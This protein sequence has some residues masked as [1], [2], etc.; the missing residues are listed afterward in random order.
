MLEL[1]GY[2]LKDI[3][4]KNIEDIDSKI[5]EIGLKEL[6]MTTIIELNIGRL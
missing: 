1:L 3:E 2:S 5:N 4:N 6:I